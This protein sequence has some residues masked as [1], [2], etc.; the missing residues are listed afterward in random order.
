MHSRDIRRPLAV[1]TVLGL[2]LAGCGGGGGEEAASEE[3][4][5]E[6][7]TTAAEEA[8]SEVAS[9]EQ[10]C[11]TTV[12]AIAAFSTGPDVDFETAAPEEIEEAMAAFAERTSPVLDDLEAA[13]PEEIGGDVETIVGLARQA[14][15]GDDSV[16]ES[17]EFVE[18]DSALDEYMLSECGYSSLDVQGM[19]YAYEGVPETLEAGT[20]GITFENAGAEVHEMVMFRLA[21][22]AGTVEELLELPDD[23]LEQQLTFVTAA[24]APPNEQDVTFVRLEEPGRYAL[25]CFIPQGTTSL[26]QLEEEPPPGETPAPDASPP[27]PPHVAL[28][29]SQ[30]LTV[31]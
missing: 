9:T 21:E 4:A 11:E 7:E 15:E 20:Y 30:E 29:M 13:A 1:L 17:P 3:P 19:D 14:L 25:V 31:E 24:F 10:F 22:D 12:D 18:A 2:L 28:G 5:T 26:E 27:A 8:T 16:F 23:Q 6:Q